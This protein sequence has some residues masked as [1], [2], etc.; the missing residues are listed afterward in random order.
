MLRRIR[1]GFGLLAAVL[2]AALGFLILRTLDTL[3]RERELEHAAVANRVFD[4]AEGALA[5]FL[6]DEQIRPAAAYR[7]RPAGVIWMEA[8]PAF[9]RAYFEIDH[10][11]RIRTSAGEPGLEAELRGAPAEGLA[12]LEQ[13]RSIRT[14]EKKKDER[15]EEEQAAPSPGTA[16]NLQSIDLVT[17][18]AKAGS[19]EQKEAGD[20]TLYSSGRALETLGRIAKTTAREKAAPA[21]QRKAQSAAERS[22]SRL[23]DF[24]ERAPDLAEAVAPSDVFEAE[25][26]L[27]DTDRMADVAPRALASPEPSSAPSVPA[28]SKKRPTPLAL[29][30]SRLSG[31]R[32][33][34]E[35]LLLYRTALDDEG[36]AV[37]QGMLVAVDA[38][39]AW[40][41]RRVLG[42]SELRDSFGLQIYTSPAE[43]AGTLPS[44]RY[45]YAYRFTEPF[46]SLSLRLAISPLD[47]G[48]NARNIGW[49][50]ALLIAASTLGLYAVYRTVSV[51]VHFAERRSNFAAAVS[52]ELKTPLTAI[53]MYGEMLRDDMVPDEAKRHEYYSTIT[54]ESERLTRL[55]NNV[56]EWSK[57]EKHQREATLVSGDV[58]SAIRDVVEIVN[59]HAAAE[60]FEIDLRLPPELPPVRHDPDA[61][62]Q[63]LYNL[64]DNAIKYAR[65]HDPARIEIGAEAVEGG[66]AIRV[67]DH[68]PGVSQEKLPLV[69][70]AFYR[71]EGELTRQTRGTGIGLALGR[72]LAESMD[73]RLTARNHPDEGF[74]IELWLS[75]A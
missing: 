13:R 60:G 30:P 26:S 72:G 22:R 29:A 69:F 12:K 64:I 44:D 32:L 24:E 59:P 3:D 21:P 28:P 14:D 34:D 10:L 68:G 7:E 53:R 25:E 46:E 37:R 15:A 43:P 55:I 41:T 48:G 4:E 52:H 67:R 75:T 54:T 49:L 42:E 74:V 61:L 31:E 62:Q 27:A 71:A 11:G 70:E 40:L 58:K 66:V 20:S 63:I 45:V 65:G 51:A 16:R 5:D 33:D 50:S 39:G 19:I 38:M 73:G 56:L 36:R 8:Q 17:G 57:L 1:L 23:D 9:V 6:R 35:R 2:V 18:R 47:D